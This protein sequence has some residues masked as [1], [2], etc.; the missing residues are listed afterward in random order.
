[1]L[2]I[3]PMLKACESLLSFRCSVTIAIS[4]AIENGTL[5]LEY[6]SCVRLFQVSWIGRHDAVISSQ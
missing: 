2:L 4:V 1:M 3:A 6:F 5:Y